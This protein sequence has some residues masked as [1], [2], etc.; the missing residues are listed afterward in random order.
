MDVGNTNGRDRPE[1]ITSAEVLD[2]I[3]AVH[4]VEPVA[5]ARPGVGRRHDDTFSRGRSH[6]RVS[7][8]RGKLD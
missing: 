7:V 5:A 4:P 1:V 6:L 3:A 8:L 2:R